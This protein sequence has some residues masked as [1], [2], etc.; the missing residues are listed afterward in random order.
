MDVRSNGVFF[1]NEPTIQDLTNCTL[2]WENIIVFEGYLSQVVDNPSLIH[3]SQTLFEKGVLKILH[4]PE[5]LK[6]ALWDKIY[7]S[8]DAELRELLF[9]NPEK[10]VKLPERPDN[11]KS[12]IEEST[13]RDN[14]DRNLQSLI[15]D[16]VKINIY[17][18]WFEPGIETV[19]KYGVSGELVKKLFSE[20]RKLADM[21]Y[22]HFHEKGGYGFSW[23]NEMLFD[24]TLMSSA[25][26]VDYAW[27]P[28]YSYK[29]GDYSIKEARRYLEG[30]NT[31]MPFVKRD[32]INDF[33]IDD[34]LEI[35]TNR[36]W[37]DAMDKMSE[38]CNEVKFHYSS[39]KFEEEMR[40]LVV[41]EMLNAIDQE[42]V[43]WDDVK[44]ETKRETMYAAIGFIPFFGGAI[45]GI[46]GMSDP[47]LGYLSNQKSQKTLPFFLNDLRKM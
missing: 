10:Y 44:E 32:S 11:F 16:I 36:R 18:E 45:S 25:L 19:E 28:Y 34:I 46:S 47:L 2:F 39:N 27:L 15:D 6:S 9:K 12:I 29:L 13:E 8:L 5:G 33:S 40:L 41:Q 14:E 38:L 35:R 43:T 17:K 42:E 37:N 24:Q 23:R 31:I 26:F 4:T 3:I 22:R 30:L 20:I 1:Y 21:Q 7:S